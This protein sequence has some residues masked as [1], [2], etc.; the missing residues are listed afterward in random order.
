MGTEPHF[1]SKAKE[2]RFVAGRRSCISQVSLRVTTSVPGHSPQTAFLSHD[3]SHLLSPPLTSSHSL[4]DIFLDCQNIYLANCRVLLLPTYPFPC[5]GSPKA[6]LGSG[7]LKGQF[8]VLRNYDSSSTSQSLPESIV[9]LP[10]GGRF[11]ATSGTSSSSDLLRH[12][13]RRPKRQDLSR[14]KK[15]PISFPAQASNHNTNSRLCYSSCSVQNTSNKPVPIYH[16]T[17]YPARETRF[18]SESGSVCRDNQISQSL[19]TL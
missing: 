10:F 1:S 5:I 12:A 8:A 13:C 15:V 4:A 2:S 9:H 18:R 14:L 19:K 11:K 7:V 16:T 6:Y 17:E 3:H